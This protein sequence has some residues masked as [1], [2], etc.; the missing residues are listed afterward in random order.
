MEQGAVIHARK[1][2]LPGFLFL[3]SPL[4]ATAED[5]ARWQLAGSYRVR[6]ETLD[7]SFRANMAGSDQLLVSRLLVGIKGRGEHVFGEIEVGDSRA[8]QDDSS[9]PLGTD[10]VNTLEPLQAYIGWRAGPSSNLAL[11]AGRMTLDIGSRRL[12][13]RNRFRNTLNTFDGVHADWRRGAWYWQAIYTRP[14]RRLPGERDKLDTNEQ[15]TDRSHSGTRFWGLH[16]SYNGSGSRRLEAYLFALGEKDG[17]DLSTRKRAIKTL[18]VRL[19]KPASPDSWDYEMEAA[20]QF[21][22]SRATAGAADIA[23]LDHR[24]VF[25]HFHYGYQFADRWASRILLQA[26]YASGDDDPLDSENNRF[27]TLY[28]ARRFEFGPTGIYGAFA[29]GNILSPGLRWQFRGNDTLSGFLG[30]R[31]VW[32]ASAG[33]ALTT[34]GVRNSGAD[35]E[36]FV[37]QQLEVRLRFAPAARV[38]AEFGAAYLHKGPLLDQAA[39]QRGDSTYWYSQLSYQ[40]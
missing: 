9:T 27:D 5:A 36:R 34:A 15:Q 10:D 17:A 28:G 11:K 19:L 22:E 40:L 33:D 23:E 26:D 29:R 24:A 1:I 35:W 13:A 37:G 14:V 7:N 32:L 6:F 31:A 39:A 25:A 4:A 3:I 16:S 30:Y 2:T 8:W 20:Y 18:G 12:V 21:G 38:R